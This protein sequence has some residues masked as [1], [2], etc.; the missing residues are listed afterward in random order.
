MLM[1]SAA[2]RTA[3]SNWACRTLPCA[4]AV[5]RKTAL[6]GETEML[7]EQFVA[8]LTVGSQQKRNSFV[9]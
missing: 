7:S 6:V 5:S 2:F 9:A 8:E 4:A 3:T 1:L